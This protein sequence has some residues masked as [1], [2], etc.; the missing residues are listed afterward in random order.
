MTYSEPISRRALLLPCRVCLGGLSSID[1][2]LFNQ[3]LSVF[4]CPSCLP[5][6]RQAYGMEITFSGCSPV[7]RFLGFKS[8]KDS[9]AAF[10]SN[11]S[12]LVALCSERHRVQQ[13][14]GTNLAEPPDIDFGLLCLPLFRLD[15]VCV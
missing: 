3:A 2:P 8:L 10:V 6:Q 9:K 7:T 11:P 13:A 1:S 12:L 14:V 5:S 15:R 4:W